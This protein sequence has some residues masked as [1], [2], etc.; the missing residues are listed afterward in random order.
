VVGIDSL[1]FGTVVMYSSGVL[2]AMQ[3]VDGAA[4]NAMMLPSVILD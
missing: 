1:L 3:P 2:M 4:N